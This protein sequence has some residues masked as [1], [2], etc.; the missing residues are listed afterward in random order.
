MATILEAR[1]LG[2]YFRHQWTFRRLHVLQRLDLDVA[3]GEIF[4][5]IG[6]NGAGKT[7]AFKLLLGL[8]RPTA[9]EVRFGGQ[10]LHPPRALPLDSCLSNRTFTNT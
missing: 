1:G 7:T 8:L 2:K 4:G 5:L 9:G 6:P 10:P 3:D